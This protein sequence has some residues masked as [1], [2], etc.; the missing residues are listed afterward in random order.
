M[1]IVPLNK[2]DLWQVYFINRSKSSL[3][4]ILVTYK[5]YNEDQKLHYC[6]MPFLTSRWGH[7]L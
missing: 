4:T 2:D 3:D 1:T 6:A 7:W 5:G